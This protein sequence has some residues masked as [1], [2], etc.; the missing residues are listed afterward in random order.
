MALPSLADTSEYVNALYVGEGG[1]GKTTASL[2]MAKLGR[3]ILVNAESGAKKRP[4]RQLGV[5]VDHIHP[6]T[7]TCYED[8]DNLYHSVDKMLKDDPGS[9]AGTVFDS[10][11]EI[12]K[13][14]TESL[15]EERH[16]RKIKGGMVDDVFETEL[17]EFGKMTEMCRRICRRFRDLP[18]H[19][20][21][22]C[23]DKRDVDSDGVVYRPDLTPKFAA[24]LVGYVDIV[25]YTRQLPGDD[26]NDRSRFIAHTR[27]DSKYKGKDRY[28][29]TP[30]ILANPTF[31]RLVEYV[32]WEEDGPMPDSYQDAYNERMAKA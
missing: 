18:C 12:Q 28:G 14:L 19:T 3:V 31:D 24:D 29:A 32:N 22:V 27:P 16:A 21:F 26:V 8:L 1:S 13:K 17:K 23:L 11:T 6:Y 25:A 2:H 15:V 30:P 5:P 4:L 7:V 10:M 20:A 9:I